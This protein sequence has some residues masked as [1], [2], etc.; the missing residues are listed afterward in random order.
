MST[1]LQRHYASWLSLQDVQTFQP[2]GI[3]LRVSWRC[4]HLSLRRR[5]E[6]STAG[7]RLGLPRGSEALPLHRSVGAEFYNHEIWGRDE[8]FIAEV[9]LAGK[10]RQI[11]RFLL[12]SAAHENLQYVEALLGLEFLELEHESR[13]IL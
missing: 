6:D 1:H 7:L 10:G 9:L 8:Q 11:N 12:G 13:P 4:E 5:S 2:S 3:I